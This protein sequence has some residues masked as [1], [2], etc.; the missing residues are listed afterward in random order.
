MLVRTKALGNAKLSVKLN[1]SVSTDEIPGFPTGTDT[2]TVSV[3][4]VNT[5]SLNISETSMAVGST[6]DLHGVIGSDAVAE[7]SQ[8]EWTVDG[9]EYVSLSDTKGQYITV[10]AK[11]ETPANTHATVTLKWTD[12]DGVTWVASCV[13]T[14]NVAATDFMITRI[15]HRSK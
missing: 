10:T 9:E 7:A 14:A 2:V 4:V 3:T 5:F 1:G 8:F 6:L 15:M 13:I 11:K 12:S